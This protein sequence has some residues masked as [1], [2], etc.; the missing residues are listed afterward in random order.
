MREKEHR[1]YKNINNRVA[2]RGINKVNIFSEAKKEISNCL[3]ADGFILSEI[4][5]VGN[6]AYI[7][8]EK[9]IK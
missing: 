9:V 3:E 4:V 2:V 1:G 8:G 7:I 6:G 5:S